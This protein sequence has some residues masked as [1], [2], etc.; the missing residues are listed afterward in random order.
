[1]NRR[2]GDRVAD[3][4]IIESLGPASYGHLYRAT[5]PNRLGLSCRS[6][7][8]KV[9]DRAAG[10]DEFERLASEVRILASVRSEHVVDVV[11]A[12]FDKGRLFYAM[13]DHGGGTLEERLDDLPLDVRLR[14]IADAAFG[15][16]ALHEVGIAH[17]DIRPATIVLDGEGAR[18]M[19]LGLAQF[20]TPGLTTR[21]EGP[22]GAV[23][24]LDPHVVL[25]AKASR[26]SDIWSLGVTLHLAA[27]GRSV[28]PDLP[29]HNIVSAL[30][31]VISHP[32]T[33]S[34]ELPPDLDELLRRCFRLGS[35]QR[36]D[37]ADD[38]AGSIQ[39][40]LLVKGRP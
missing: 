2:I 14:A 16:H 5:C 1:M 27:T 6:V 20:L 11:D 36:F 3:Y 23:E 4:S 21:G 26:R 25:G 40:T 30:R 37:S 12:G 22:V 7:I 32:P 19:D 35:H 33:L 28:H 10:D 9:L 8:V 34:E 13:V 18:L 31:H 38:L 17:R 29:D 15:A 24:F 39:S